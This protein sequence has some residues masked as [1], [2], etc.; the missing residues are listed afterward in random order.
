MLCTLVDEYL[1]SASD[2][3]RCG[4]ILLD[5]PLFSSDR[6]YIRN[7]LIGRMRTEDTNP[8]LYLASSILL[9]DGRQNNETFEVMQAEGLFP[10]LLELIVGKKSPEDKEC[11]NR[12]LDVLYEMS[13]M[14]RLKWG[15]LGRCNFGVSN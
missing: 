7:R 10:R 8:V 4:Y 5:S 6:T 15:D 9:Y 3:A 11:R 2:W 13:R 1:K 14:Q 12:L